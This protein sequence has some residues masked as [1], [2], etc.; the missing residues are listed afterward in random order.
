MPD[1]VGG[2]HGP[3]C[4]ARGDGERTLTLLRGRSLKPSASRKARAAATPSGPERDEGDP[5]A[6]PARH[7][8]V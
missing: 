4:P 2:E 7:R 5:A 6:L 3:P 8:N 1:L